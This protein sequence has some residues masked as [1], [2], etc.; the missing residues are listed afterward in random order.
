MDIL[1]S[2]TEYTV[3][4]TRIN[5][6]S[7]DKLI[8]DFGNDLTD[9]HYVRFTGDIISKYE[10]NEDAI[11]YDSVD[12]LDN[13]LE[14]ILE[15]RIGKHPH[16]LVFAKGVRWNGS[17]G[18]SIVEDIKKTCYKDYDVTLNIIKEISGKAIICRESSHDV[19]MGSTTIIIGINEEQFE[20]FKDSD[21]SIIEQFAYSFL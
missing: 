8:N 3:D 16:Y 20:K 18:Y 12:F 4:V 15:S 5:K 6:E 11:D 13:L 2:C 17:S 7:L 21:F 1:E 9:M 10:I 19:P 14:D